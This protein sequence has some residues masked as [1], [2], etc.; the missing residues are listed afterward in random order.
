[1]IAG[2]RVLG[3]IPARGGSRR[4]PRKNIRE[5]G[6]RP[7]IMWTIEAA[8]KSRFIDCLMVSSED[9]EIL[10]KVEPTLSIK[11]PQ[12]LA[13]HDTTSEAVARH[14]LELFPDFDYVVLLQPTSPLRIVEDIDGAIRELNF[15]EKATCATCSTD[16]H[17][18]VHWNG[19]VYVA[20]VGHLRNHGRFVNLQTIAFMMPHSRSLDIDTE[21]DLR[22][23]DERLRAR[24]VA[25]ACNP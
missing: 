3:L 18:D 22:K 20:K 15:R 25:P 14:A 17:S 2:K 1:M 9:E 13:T 5:V 10:R 12:H 8:L 16:I 19:A 4:A 7:L 6:G 23:A 21:D 24:V 11:R